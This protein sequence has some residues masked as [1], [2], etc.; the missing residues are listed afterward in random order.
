[1]SPSDTRTGS[2]KSK[3]RWLEEAKANNVL[4]RNDIDAHRGD[5]TH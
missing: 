2:R 1:M 5:G 4:P 3:A